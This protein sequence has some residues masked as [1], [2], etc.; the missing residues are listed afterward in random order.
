[1]PKSRICCLL[2]VP[3]LLLASALAADEETETAPSADSPACLAEEM[4]H[5]GDA[6]IERFFPVAPEAAREA[7]LEAIKPLEFVVEQSSDAEIQAQR[8]RHF[9]AL[10]GA[11]GENLI[12]QLVAAEENGVSGT[13]VSAQT[14][15]TFAGRAGQKNWTAAVLARLDCL[16]QGK[17]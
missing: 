8:K 4:K 9:G 5:G 17:G 11:G 10:V 6:K 7:L 15:K 2:A 1:M 16:L 3:L 14:K 13:K 12:V